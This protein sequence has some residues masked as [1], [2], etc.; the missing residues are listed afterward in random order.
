MSVWRNDINCRYMFMFPL[1]KITRKRLINVT[2]ASEHLTD[3]DSGSVTKLIPFVPLFSQFFE[4]SK[5]WN[6]TLLFYRHRSAVVTFSRHQWDEYQKPSALPAMC[7][8]WLFFPHSLSISSRKSGD[9]RNNNYRQ[10]S[11]IRRIKCQHLKDSCT[12][13]RLSLSNPLKPD[14]K[15]RMKM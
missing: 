15:S 2:D 5:H 3:S 9:A 11:N 8:G 10:V 13:L 7:A 14:V 1:K 12:G 6:I 4:L